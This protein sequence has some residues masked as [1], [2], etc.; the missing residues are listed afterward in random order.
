[1]TNTVEV[2]RA[3]FSLL[4]DL[5]KHG[6]IRVSINQPPKE[7]PSFSL[8]GIYALCPVIQ[9]KAPY[10]RNVLWATIDAHGGH[11]CG[12]GFRRGKNDHYEWYQS[13][14]NRT[15]FT[16][17]YTWIGKETEDY[18]LWQCEEVTQFILNGE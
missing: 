9:Q 11:G 13:Q 7:H 4:E 12:N 10:S 14:A 16:G 5:A 6:V 2:I 1:M 18:R 15:F 8:P 17:H 3:T